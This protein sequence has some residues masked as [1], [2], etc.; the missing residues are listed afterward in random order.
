MRVAFLARRKIIDFAEPNGPFRTP[1]T[2]QISVICSGRPR[3]RLA[4]RRARNRC[5][6]RGHLADYLAGR[7]GRA[8]DP[9]ATERLWLPLGGGHQIAAERYSPLS[10]SVVYTE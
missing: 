10:R 2:T 4:R 5:R 6:R 8:V 7:A 9:S 1:A 3:W